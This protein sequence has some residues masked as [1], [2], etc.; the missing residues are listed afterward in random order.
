MIEVRSATKK[1]AKISG[2]EIKKCLCIE[3]AFRQ[4]VIMLPVC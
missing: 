3:V 2:I 1:E 4:I